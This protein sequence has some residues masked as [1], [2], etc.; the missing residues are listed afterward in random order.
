MK[1]TLAIDIGAS[2]GRHIIG[3]M[4]NG[5]MV[6]EEI[7]RFPNYMDGVDGHRV[8]DTKRLFNEILAGLIKAK[9][10]GKIPETIGIDT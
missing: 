5:K 10:I 7:Y 8:W 4:E 2:S 9:E 1:Y 3:Y 6:L